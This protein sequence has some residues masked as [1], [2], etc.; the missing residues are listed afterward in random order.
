MPETSC[1]RCMYHGSRC[2]GGDIAPADDSGAFDWMNRREDDDDKQD[3]ENVDAPGEEETADSDTNAQ[4]LD[5]EEVAT[6]KEVTENAIDETNASHC[7]CPIGSRGV[8]L[9]GLGPYPKTNWQLKSNSGGKCMGSCDECTRVY[10]GN[11]F[12][13]CVM[14]DRPGQDPS[15]Q[16]GKCGEESKKPEFNNEK[17]LCKGLTIY[18]AK[19]YENDNDCMPETSCSKCTYQGYTC[20]SR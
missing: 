8:N 6:E 2:A 9:A 5:D 19:I 10:G 11:R 12:P 14:F 13:C 18:K 17:C 3:G 15:F 7:L 1:S 4:D 20:A 16:S